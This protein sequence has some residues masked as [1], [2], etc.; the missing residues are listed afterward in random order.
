M[1]S[2]EMVKTIFNA[3]EE[4]KG[5]HISILDISDISVIADY[6]IIASGNN[7]NQLQALCDSVKEELLKL[8]VEPKNVEGYN[9]G[10]W[11]LL[12]YSDVVVHIFSKEARMFYDIER[13]WKDA[14]NV[15]FV[16]GSY[17][18]RF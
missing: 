11:I 8:G 9:D 16:G 13:V 7:V 12:D 6:F 2:K 10:T 15:D 17:G 1:N 4:K 3:L 14:K 18:V 5:E